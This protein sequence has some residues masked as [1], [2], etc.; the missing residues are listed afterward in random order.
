M[1]T[2]IKNLG[3]RRWSKNLNGQLM[4]QGPWVQFLLAS[5]LRIS[6]FS[7]YIALEK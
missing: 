3:L 2:K 6:H 7:F 4:S 5:I 1:D